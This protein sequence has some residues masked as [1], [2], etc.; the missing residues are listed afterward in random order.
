MKKS[1]KILIGCIVGGLILI[2]VNH[3]FNPPPLEYT[4]YTD[5]KFQ[6]DLQDYSNASIVAENIRKELVDE[7]SLPRIYTFGT[8]FPDSERP[9]IYTLRIV[10][11]FSENSPIIKA[12]KE[13]LETMPEV[14]QL[15]GPSIWCPPK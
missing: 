5:F 6:F 14:S 11:E 2:Q 10:G 15:T 9:P 13:I 12:I 4:C 8:W 7:F 1:Y 3:F